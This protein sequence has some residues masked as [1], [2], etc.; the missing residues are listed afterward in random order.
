MILNYFLYRKVILKERENYY[1]VL[2]FI[3]IQTRQ[4]FSVKLTV[5]CLSFIQEFVYV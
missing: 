3:V 4:R 2:S 1:F 5:L